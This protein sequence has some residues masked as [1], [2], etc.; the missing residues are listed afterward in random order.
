[1]SDTSQIREHELW[2]LENSVT[3]SDD[4]EICEETLDQVRRLIA[5]VRRR[6]H[7]AGENDLSSL[8][9]HCRWGDRWEHSDIQN[10]TPDLAFRA[11]LLALA[12][13]WGED[14]VDLHEMALETGLEPE[15]IEKHLDQLVQAKV[16][17]EP[18]A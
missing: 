6:R 3:H 11:T 15:V 14:S 12:R 7:A 18:Q 9:E 2:Y 10:A 5:E 8:A 13:R 1:M 4:R 16:L 17:G